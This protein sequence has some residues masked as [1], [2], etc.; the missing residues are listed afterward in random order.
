MEGERMEALMRLG[1]IDGG[2]R[3]DYT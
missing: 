2:K 1:R 3:R